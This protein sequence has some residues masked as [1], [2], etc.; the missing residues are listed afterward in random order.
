MWTYYMPIFSKQDISESYS[1]TSNHLK[2]L[3]EAQENIFKRIISQDSYSYETL[4]IGVPY[5]IGA[6]TRHKFVKMELF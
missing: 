4:E 2:Q 6:M 5:L 1:E 3:N